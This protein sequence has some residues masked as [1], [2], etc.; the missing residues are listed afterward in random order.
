L[1]TEFA[2]TFFSV[3]LQVKGVFCDRHVMQSYVNV[4]YLSN[5]LTYLEYFNQH[6][7]PTKFFA[8]VKSTEQYECQQKGITIETTSKT[9]T[10][11]I[12]NEETYCNFEKFPNMV[13]L[14]TKWTLPLKPD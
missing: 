8:Y 12:L 13:S 7:M 14:I 1:R 5:P 4:A 9:I 10:C 3:L 2:K 6:A 11:P